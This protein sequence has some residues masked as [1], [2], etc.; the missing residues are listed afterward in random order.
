M[1]KS[2]LTYISPSSELTEP[3]SLPHEPLASQFS[4]RVVTATVAEDWA[5]PPGTDG[6]HIGALERLDLAELSAA[7]LPDLNLS[8]EL[9][10]LSHMHRADEQARVAK[11]EAA[12]FQNRDRG[13]RRPYSKCIF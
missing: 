3:A 6:A 7:A 11:A 10:R 9:A 5:E 8:Q 1:Y 4:Q 13:M 2:P 12:H